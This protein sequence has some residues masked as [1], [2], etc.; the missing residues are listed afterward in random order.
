MEK[1][2]IQ[3]KI[4]RKLINMKP[5]KWG[6]SHTEEINLVKSLPKHLRGEK[7]VDEAIKELNKMDFLIRLKKTREWHVSKEEIYRFLGIP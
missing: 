7:V 1:K 4:L 2:D 3:D 6:N 5:H